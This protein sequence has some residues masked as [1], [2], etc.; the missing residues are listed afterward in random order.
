MRCCGVANFF[1]CGVTVN[2]ISILRCCGD[3]KPVRC[4]VFVILSLR[5]SVK[6]NN[7]RTAL[8]CCGYYFCGVAVLTVLQ[9]LPL[10]KSL[11]V[12]HGKI[13][14]PI[15]IVRHRQVNTPVY[16]LD[17][18]KLMPQLYLLDTGKSM[19]QCIC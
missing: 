15:V 3:L 19:L 6:R 2:K 14:A 4:A 7:L 1:L 5:Y 11:F 9:S 17:R 10:L 13:N 18:G 16:L 12:R 8:R